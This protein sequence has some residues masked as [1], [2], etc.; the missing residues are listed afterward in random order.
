M[1]QGVSRAALAGSKHRKGLK[2]RPG[3]GVGL[4][5]LSRYILWGL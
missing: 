4:N 2:F 1:G 3:D 5:D